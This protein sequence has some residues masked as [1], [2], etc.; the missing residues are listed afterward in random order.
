MREQRGRVERVETRKRIE[1]EEQVGYGR[2]R[3][4]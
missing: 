1:G 3:R 2:A 4:R